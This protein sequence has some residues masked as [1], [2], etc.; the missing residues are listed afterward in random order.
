MTFNEVL[1]RRLELTKEVLASK[2]KE[3]SGGGD[4]RFHN[5]DRAA[6][7]LGTTPEKALLGMLA[8]HFISFFDLM[9]KPE[10]ATDSLIDEK[11]GDAI[12]YLILAEGMLKRRETPLTGT[13]STETLDFMKKLD[14]LHQKLES[15]KLR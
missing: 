15:A 2:G 11:I 9:E 7:M 8:K 3:Y 5:F 1:E 13:K 14:N 4:N 10:E 12:N 6:Q